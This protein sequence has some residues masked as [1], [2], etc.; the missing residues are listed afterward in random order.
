MVIIWMSWYIVSGDFNYPKASDGGK[1][2]GQESWL[3]GLSPME[4]PGK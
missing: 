3:E 1:I 4:S 2:L